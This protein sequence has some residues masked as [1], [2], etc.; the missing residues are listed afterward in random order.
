VVILQD[1]DFDYDV[2]TYLNKEQRN[3]MLELERI[4]KLPEKINRSSDL[5]FKF[6][7]GRPAR[8]AL[9]LDLV[10]S[11]FGTLG[12]SKLKTIEL[13]NTEMSPDNYKKE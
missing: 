1:S 6:L 13:L 7:L 9:L 2:V 12:Y 11:I 3:D 8:T 10:N 5:F 4:G